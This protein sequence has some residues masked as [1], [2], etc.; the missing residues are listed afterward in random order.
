[1]AGHAS[2]PV[3]L[4]H[5]MGSSFDHNWRAQGWVDLLVEAGR[6]VVPV[7]LPGHGGT[8][9]LGDEESAADRLLEAAGS[10][11]V[12]AVGFSAGASALYEAVVRDDLGRFRRVALL[13][14]GDGIVTRTEVGIPELAQAVA[15]AGDGV[16]SP[17]TASM[18]RLLRQS[19]LSA[20]NDVDDVVDYIRR[21]P[22]PPSLA[23][24]V[25]RRRSGA[26]GFPEILL[27]TGADDP[28]GPGDA[29]REALGARSLV[30]PRV[31]HFAT[32]TSFTCQVAVL[33]FLDGKVSAA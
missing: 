32:T 26:A 6:T 16:D 33:D 21:M 19:A 20:G 14:L 10:G 11:P 23:A 7:H 13:G 18:G 3:L 25:D 8:P 4:L 30:I 27:V 17:A 5:G 24:A 2:V 29:V 31:D 28:I 1:M 9:R 12:D 15:G 22:P